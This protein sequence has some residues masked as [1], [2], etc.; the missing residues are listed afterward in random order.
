MTMTRRTG[1]WLRMAL[2]LAIALLHLLNCPNVAAMDPVQ[3]LD[4]HVEYMTVHMLGVEQRV[5]YFLPLSLAR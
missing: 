4:W 1:A 3:E 2:G 5:R